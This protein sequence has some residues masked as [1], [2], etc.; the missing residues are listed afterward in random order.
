MKNVELQTW[1]SDEVRFPTNP[2]NQSDLCFRSQCMSFSQSCDLISK[3]SRWR[4]MERRKQ[5]LSQWIAHTKEAMLVKNIIIRPRS[6]TT[7]YT[8]STLNHLRTEPTHKCR[9]R[10]S[11]ASQHQ[12]CSRKK[13][14]SVTRCCR[15]A[16]TFSALRCNCKVVKMGKKM[17]VMDFMAVPH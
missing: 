6:H 10:T 5:R 16:Q 7:N 14:H 17:R 3:Q 4:W 12:G 11:R 2:D 1:Q 13:R 9:R 15:R 8:F